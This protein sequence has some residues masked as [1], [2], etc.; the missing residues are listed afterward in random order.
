MYYL[1]NVYN[2][3]IIIGYIYIHF[4]YRSIICYSPKINKQNILQNICRAHIF[5]YEDTMQY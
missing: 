2:I 4:F 3:Y 1:Y 5:W